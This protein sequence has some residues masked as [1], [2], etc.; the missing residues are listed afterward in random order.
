MKQPIQFPKPT[1][2][3]RHRFRFPYPFFLKIPEHFAREWLTHL[4]RSEILVWFA[5]V[6]ATWGYGK[7]RDQISIDQLR[8][9]KVDRDGKR[10]T[11][12]TGLSKLHTIR[13]IQELE[14]LGLL[15][16]TRHHRSLSTFEPA[17]PRRIL[18]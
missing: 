15:K 8:S 16:V 2:P 12:G 11:D 7:L 3:K 1:T 17:C 9:G 13:A 10:I 14:R 5:C 4:S 6:D 18:G